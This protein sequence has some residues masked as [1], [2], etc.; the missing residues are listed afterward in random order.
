VVL[1]NKK[2]KKERWIAPT[3]KVWFYD[4]AFTCC[5]ALLGS[6]ENSRLLVVMIKTAGPIY[7]GQVISILYHNLYDPLIKRYRPVGRAAYRYT[8]FDLS[9][10]CWG[11]LLRYH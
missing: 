3:L 1:K 9:A 10:V 7:G 4:E 8:A 11:T 5:Y 2:N 6:Y